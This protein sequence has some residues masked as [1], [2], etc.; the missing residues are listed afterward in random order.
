L[1]RRWHRYPGTPSARDVGMLLAE[2]EHNATGA[3]W[4]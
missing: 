1:S 3:F 2:I 4:G